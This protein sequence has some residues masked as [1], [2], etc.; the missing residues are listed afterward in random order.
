MSNNNIVT[1][2][3]L[4]LLYDKSNFCIGPDFNLNIKKGELLGIVG[5]S[6]CGK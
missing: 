2:K 1:I 4:N 5:E 6:G 3:N